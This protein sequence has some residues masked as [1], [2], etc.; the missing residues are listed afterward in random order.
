MIVLTMNVIEVK[1]EVLKEVNEVYQHIYINLPKFYK[2]CRKNSIKVKYHT[3]FYTSK[4]R[5]KYQLI[6]L[7]DKSGYGFSIYT[8]YTDKHGSNFMQIVKD[9]RTLNNYNVINYNHHFLQRYRERVIEDELLSN[10]ETI[11]QKEMKGGT[12]VIN[13]I[14]CIDEAEQLYKSSM[15]IKTGQA[16][17][18]Y[19]KNEKLFIANT[20]ISIEQLKTNQIDYYIE[21]EKAIN[22]YL[23]ISKELNIISGTI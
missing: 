11:L 8:Y 20:F 18:F 14:D 15:T 21:N 17:G 12:G 13:M 10:F 23:N 16:L 1:N 4:R 19:L 9:E 3:E 22:S 7:K 6:Y 2:Y 5:N